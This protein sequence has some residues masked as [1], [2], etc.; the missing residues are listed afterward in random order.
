MFRP[1]SVQ[2]LITVYSFPVRNN[3]PVEPSV[4]SSLM[5]WTNRTWGPEDRQRACGSYTAELRYCGD[6]NVAFTAALA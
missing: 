2:S 6:G 5:V 3:T 1:A 4:Y